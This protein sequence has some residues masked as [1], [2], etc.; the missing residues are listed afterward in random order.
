MT[1]VAAYLIVLL[2]YLAYRV[3]VLVKDM[4]AWYRYGRCAA[5]LILKKQ[6]TIST[7]TRHGNFLR[8]AY[9]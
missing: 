3:L 2:A 8:Q 5:C 9:L 1:I 7:L 6:L 4:K